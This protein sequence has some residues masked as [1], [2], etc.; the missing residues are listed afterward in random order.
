MTGVLI[1]DF[2]AT[3][4]NL[5]QILALQLGD[6]DFSIMASDFQMVVDHL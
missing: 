3:A 5:H 4:I 6:I 2:P 1:L